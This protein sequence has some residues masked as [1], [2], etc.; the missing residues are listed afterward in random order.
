MSQ[1]SITEICKTSLFDDR[2][3]LLKRFEEDR[4]EHLMRIREMYLYMLNHPTTTDKSFVELYMSRFGLT[5]TP[6]YQDLAVIKTLLPLL[7]QAN[8][9]FHRWRANQMLLETYE[10]AKNRKDTRT[11]EKAASSY[12]K[13]NRVDVEDEVQ[14][15]YDKILI[16]PFIATSD[17]SVLGIKPI[18]NLRERIA[19]VKEKYMGKFPDMVDV[20]YEEVDLRE[21]EFYPE[22]TEETK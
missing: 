3:K 2:E 11:M 6:A 22:E 18:P 12:A 1:V 19:K 16:Q 14:I 7:S 10:L 20:V 15:P 4:V 13:Y 5:K 17:P 21:K 9:D 8:R